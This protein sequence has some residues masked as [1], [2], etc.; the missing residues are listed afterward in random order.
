VTPPMFVTRY[1]ATVPSVAPLLPAVAVD[2]TVAPIATCSAPATGVADVTMML[3]LQVE[4]EK[5][6]LAL[7]T[8]IEACTQSLYAPEMFAD[9]SWPV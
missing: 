2:A 7:D 9:L 3:D 6:L 8:V 5:L 4:P 1:P